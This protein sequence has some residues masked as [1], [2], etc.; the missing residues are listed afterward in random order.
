MMIHPDPMYAGYRHP[1]VIISYA[2]WL[3]FRFPLS[4]HTVEEMPAVRGIMV[5]HEMARHWRLKFSRE[6][7][8]HLRR[9]EPR[10]GHKWH[11]DGL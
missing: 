1:P 2:V 6:I 8:N 9:R 3:Y 10:R 5:S 7:A 11:M 4:L